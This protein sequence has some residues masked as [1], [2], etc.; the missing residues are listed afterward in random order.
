MA[1]N[2]FIIHGVHGNPEE[3]WL[4]WLK[5]ELEGLGHQVFIPKFP[6]PEGN[7][8]ENWLKV[9][10]NY[11]DHL[12]KD[13]IVIG[14]SLGTPFLLTILE[15]NPVAKA[16]FVA[17][18]NPESLPET[19]EWYPMVKT[20]V[21]KPF[22]W[23]KIRKNCPNFTI[24]HA[25][26]DPYFPIQLAEDLAKELNT[27]VKLIKNAGHFNEAAGYTKFEKLLEDIK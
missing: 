7:T 27:G 13:S 19:D 21:D 3:N 5:T 11:K 24:Y 18:Y 2:V 6:T 9:F 14:H 12:N 1:H 23:G 10:E 26:N 16:Y 20:F 8:L 17:G 15:K 4:P 25:D 22:N